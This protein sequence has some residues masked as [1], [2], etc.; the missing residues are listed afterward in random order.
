MMPTVARS[1]WQTLLKSLF[2]KRRPAKG[3]SGPQ[4][5][6]VLERLETRLAPAN[7]TWTGGAGTLVWTDAN[8]WSTHAVPVTADDVTINVTVAGPI[9]VSGT[10]SI[11]SLTDTTAPLVL[12]SGSFTFAASSSVSKTFSVSSGTLTANGGLTVNSATFNF[13]GGSIGGTVTL[14]SSGLVIGTGSTGA[15]N[16]VLEGSDTL[17]GNV[18]AGQSLWV[19]GNGTTN[20]SATL[21]I[22]GNVTNHGTI[23]LESIN[24]TYGD[25]L[26]TG[27]NTFTNAADGTIQVTNNSGGARAITG[28]LV[29]Q[30]QISV[31]GASYLTVQGTYY[32]AGGSISGPGYLLNTALYVTT[33][34]ASPTTILLEGGGDTLATDNLPNTTLWVQG[35]GYLNQNATLNVAAGLVNH[36]T[37][38]L[39]SINNTYG[40]TL[41]T[42]SNTF[43]NAADGTIQVTNNSG[44]A[45]AI[46]GTL[47][48][49][50][51]V[52][53]DT[54]TTLGSSG[55]KAINAGLIGIAGSTVTVVGSSFTNAVGGLVSGDGSFITP[56]VT[57]TNNGIIDLSRPSILGVDAELSF[58]TITYDDAGAM[59]ATT[60]TNAANYT[61]LGSGGDGIFGNGNDVNESSLISQVTYNATTKTATL[62]LSSQLP[63][64]VYWVEVNGSNV[65]DASG[66]ALLAG[67]TD[68]V[69]RVVG[70]ELAQVA[71]NL[72]PDSNSGAPDHPGYT[73]ISTPTFDFQVNQAGTIAVDFDGNGTTDATLPVPVAG[74]YQLT[75]PKLADG[76]YTATATFTAATRLT[77][78]GSTTYT[79]DT[80][81][82]FVTSITPNG[83][84]NNAVSQVTVTFSEPVDLNTFS[85]AAITLTGPSGSVAVKQPQL[86]SGTT[87]SIGFASQ[88]VQGA[89]TLTIASTVADFAGNPLAP[90]FNGSFTIALPDLA[91][92]TT[93]APS[94]AIEGASLPISWTVT[95]LSATNPAVF[96]W[97]DTVYLSAR[98]VLDNKATPLIEVAAPPQSPLAGN[99][100]YTRNETVTLPANVATG[101]YYLLFAANADAG[102]LE[103]DAGNDTNDLVAEP[104]TLTAPDLQVTGVSGP[105][106]GFNSQ[107]V[108]VSWTDVNNGD[109]P[110]AGPW[111]DNVYAATDAK[112]DGLTLLGS[113]TFLGPLAVGAS[114][115]RTQQ[116]PLPQ[117]PGTYWFAVTTNATQSV[118]EGTHFNNDTTVATTPV[119]VAQVPLPDLVVTSITPP[120]NGVISGTSVPISF[121]V[122]NQGTAP[123]SVPVWHDWVVLSQDPT[124]A[125]TYGGQLNGT[126]PGG[127]QTLNN[128][129][130]IVGFTNP[131][132]LGV[133]E[134]YQQ[135]VNVTLP[136]SAQG[137]WY[138]YV[139]PDGT[140]LHH[141]FAMPELS[142]TDKLAVSAGFSVALT[143]LPDLS[144]TSVQAPSQDFSGQP[145]KLSWTV[146]NGGTGATMTDAWADAVYMSPHPVLDSNATELGTFTHHGV[147]AAGE[148]YTD[149][150][151]VN[152]PVGVSGPFYFLVQTDV[153]GQVFEINPIGNKVAATATAETVNLTPP[154]D[155]QVSA[156][157]TPAT[158]VASHALTFSYT[159]TNAGAGGT[160]NFAWDDSFYLSPTATYDAATA[161]PLGQAT[162]GGSLDAGA[163]YTN[164]I[165]ETL[166]NGISGAYYLLADTDSGNAVFELDKTNNWSAS[167]GTIQVSSAPADLVVSAASAPS[168]ALA[169]SAVLVTWT[170]TNEGL[171]DT[172]ISSW[173]DDIYA[174]TSATLTS[175]AVLLGSFTHVGLL[176]PG[177]SYTQ[178]E[179]VTVPISFLGAYNIFVVANASKTVYV[180]G[181]NNTSSPVPSTVSLQLTNS[182][183][184]TQKAAVSDLQPTSVTG[185]ASA[186]TGGSVSVSWVVQNNGPGATNSDYW[187]DDVWMSTN[188]TLGGG[189]TDIYLG[190]VQ[191]TNPLA[192]GA[193]YSASGTFTL[194]N[195]LAAGNYYFIV[196][197]DR[198]VAPPNDVQG[199][200]LVHET[201][202]ANN[203]MPASTI[204]A[205]SVAPAPELTVSNVTVPGP[206]VSGVQLS[207]G[208]T[209]TNTGADTG[210]VPITDSVY[211]SYDQV[212]DPSDRYVGSVTHQGGLAGGASY[213]Q[214]ATLPLPPGV[215]GTFYVVVVTNS[216]NSVY[217]RNPVSNAAYGPQRVEIDL[218]PIADLVAGT[219]LIPANATAGQ[220]ITITYQVSNGGTNAANGTWYD[221]LYL[222]PTPT[223]SVT[224]PL[225]GRVSQTQDLAPAASYTGTLTAPLPGVAPGSYYVIVRS[226]ILNTLPELT[227]DNNLSASQTELA[228]DAPALTLS[229][230]T[231]GTLGEGQSAYYK[232]DVTA[233]QTLQIAFASQSPSASNELYVNYGTMPTRSQ[234]QYRYGQPLQSDQQ[235]T[236]PNTQAGTYY[237]LAYGASV[238]GASESYTITPSLLP[239]SIT[240]VTPSQVGNAGQATLEIEGA[241][242]DNGTT[243]QLV[244]ANGDVVPDRAIYLQDSST[245]FVTFQLTEQ[246]LGAY[247][248]QAVQ[249]DGAAT[250]LTGGVTIVTGTG[251]KLQTSLAIPSFVLANQ[252]DEFNVGYAN[253]GDADEIAPL[254]FVYSSTNTP[255]GLTP[256]E[257]VNGQNVQF[258]AV[259]Q[260]GP[261]GILRPGTSFSVPVYFNNEGRPF[262]FQVYILDANNPD[263]IDW[264][265][266]LGMISPARLGDPHWALTYAQLQK[267]LGATW[268]SFVR[269]LANDATNPTSTSSSGRDPASLLD[270]EVKRAAGVDPTYELSLSICD[271]GIHPFL[272]PDLQ[273]NQIYGGEQM[274]LPVMLTNEGD[275]VTGTGAITFY[276][277]PTLN[278]DPTTAIPIT[279]GNLAGLPIFL[280]ASGC[281][282]FT[283]TITI[284][285]LPPFPSLL[286]G[287]NPSSGAMLYVI[288]QFTSDIPE[289][290]SLFNGGV[291]PNNIATSLQTFEYVGTP[292]RAAASV[293][294]PVGVYL[295]ILQDTLN[296]NGTDPF[297]DQKSPTPVNGP[298]F[299]GAFES[300][301]GYNNPVLYPY[302][303]SQGVPTISHGVNLEEVQNN[304]A[305]AEVKQALADDVRAYYLTQGVFL[306][307]SDDDIID[308]LINESLPFSRNGPHAPT[309]LTVAEAL[310]VFNVAY[311]LH[312]N[313]AMAYVGSNWSLLSSDAQ[314]AITDL[315]YNAN[316]SSFVSL[317][318]DLRA[319]YIDYERAGF[320]LLNSLRTLQVGYDRSLADYKYLLAGLAPE[321]GSYNPNGPT[322]CPCMNAP[323]P[324]P[325]PPPPPVTEPPSIP[326]QPPVDNP[327]AEVPPGDPG[328]QGEG[329]PRTKRDPNDIIGPSGAGDNHFVPANATLGYEVLFENEPT[330]TAPVQEVV[331]T[332]QLDPNLDW[333]TFRLG[334]FG[335]GGM[336]FQVPAN[337]AYYQTL[338]DFTQTKGFYVELTANIDERT[339]IATWTFTTIDPAAGEIPLDPSVGFLPP[340]DANG[341]GEGFVS[342][343]VEA[344]LADTTGTVIN[345]QA[346][347]VFDT[348]PPLNTPKIFNTIDTGTSLTSSV[349]A[350]PDRE[351][352]TQFNVFWSGTDAGNGSA[353]SSFTIYVSDNGGPY[354]TW[355][356][357]TTLTSAP[358]VGQDGH[359]YAFYSVAADNAGNVQSVPTSAQATTTI[360]IAPPVSS[361]AT[362][363]QFSPGTVTVSWSGTDPNGIGI[364]SYSVYVS[365]DGGA[366]TLWLTDTIQTTADYAGVNGHTYGFYSVAT[367]NLGN[368][369]LPPPSAQA[370][371]TVDALPPSS[372]VAAL[373]A[374]S[375]PIFTV[376]WSGT[377]NPGGSGLATYDVYVSDDGAAFTPLLTATTLTST[378][379]TG[380]DGHTYS[381]YSVAADNVGNVQPTPSAAQANT[382]VDGT[383]PN[384]TVVALPTFSPGSFTVNWSGSDGSGSGIATYNIYVSD[385]GG[386]FT[387]L[388]TNTTQTT[389]TYTG[390]D[391]H[392]YGFYAVATD[393]VGNIQPTPTGAQATTT[394]DGTPPNSS[395]A[396][397]PAFS[398]ATFVLGWSGGDGDGSGIATYS[399]YVS[400]NGGP[401][402]LLLGNTT[403][404]STS[405]AGQNGHTYG[406]Y[407]VATDNVGN[408]QPT[409][410][411]AQAS[412]TVSST[413]LTAM[414]S[415]PSAGVLY[416]PLAFTVGASDPNPAD[417][418]GT[419]TYVLNWGDGTKDT[420]TAPATAADT[421]AYTKVGTYTVTLTATDQDKN[422]S[423]PVSQQVSVGAA[424]QLQDG[425]LAVPGT[426][427]AAT[428]TLT[429]TL[430]AGAIAYSMKVSYT[431]GG[432]T[433]TFGP[434][435]VSSIEVYGGP[436]TD[437]VTLGGTSGSDDFTVG[438]A[439]LSELAAQTTPFTVTLSAIA[440]TSLNGAGGSDS[441]TGPNGANTWAI[442]GKNAGTLN[443]SAA[444]TGIENLTGGSIQD[445]FTFDS[446]GSITGDLVGVAPANTVDLSQ[447][448]KPVTVN[449]QTTKATAVGGT[450]SNI[451]SFIGTDTT[452]A[453]VAANATNTWSI[454]GADAGAVDGVSFEGFPNLTGGTTNDTFA[455]LPAGSIDGSI[456]GGAPVNTLD[457]SGYG[458]R[459]TVNLATKTA[460]GV[461]GTWSGIQD[462]VGTGTADA[463][464]G[465]DANSTWSITGPD[466]GTV[467][468]YSFA[469]FP[470]LTGGTGND[471]FKFVSPGSLSGAISGGGGNDTIIGDN[472]DNTFTISGINA[473]SIASI[474]PHG[475]SGIQNLTGGSTNDTFIFMPGGSIAG[476][477]KGG[478]PVNTLDYSAYGSAVVVNLAAKTATGIGGTWSNI[479]R[480]V[481]TDTADT[482]VGAAV[483]STWSIT[484]PDAGTVGAY[485]FAGF[486]N[487]T[488]GTTGDDTFAFPAGGS[489]SGTVTGGG[490]T[491]TLDLSGYGSPV[492]VNLQ[493]WTATGVG[494][495]WTD[496]QSFKGTNTTDSL[497]ATD[498]TTNAWALKGSN[499]GTVNGASF[500]GFAN[501]VG[502]SGN[503][504]FTFANKA[505]V[506][507]VIDG[508]GG[509]NTLD[510]SAYTGGVTVNLGSGTTDLANDSATGV[511]GGTADGIAN[512]AN[513]IVGAGNNYLTAVGLTTS[514]TFT[515][516]GTGNNILV[517]GAGSNTLTASGSGN[518]I[519]IG[520]KGT[521]AING[522]TGYNLLVGGYTA[523]DIVSADLQSI[524]GIWKTVN[525]ATTYSKAIARLTLATYAYALTAASVHGNAGDTINAGTHLLDWYFATA[526]GEITGETAGETVT[527]C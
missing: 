172:A 69:N 37:I 28:T 409:P 194:P 438:N 519:V 134:S 374:F 309:A 203:E 345:A 219:V 141:P 481:G 367:D 8:N 55:A 354:T 312:Q 400:D 80:A 486:P 271:D 161:I 281:Q 424:P 492:T 273:P 474:L 159:V 262:H 184:V 482:L 216:N 347:V 472:N 315:T 448:G 348:E 186:A 197:T 255:M 175:Q 46:T 307:G 385:D 244:D 477:L 38:L 217:E 426:A 397:L 199:V 503:D 364:A 63:S 346:T 240:Q 388:L 341:S 446:G 423:Q 202:E 229:V 167:A 204:T 383:P 363:P 4:A 117:T 70:V 479:Q 329:I 332:E 97:T 454:S 412:T 443:G 515:A 283:T 277:S 274:T 390:Q 200:N 47:V 351:T 168:A 136:L 463:L 476:D 368:Q 527:L 52:N 494:G 98:A 359:T 183:G 335:F 143:P 376:S 408:V 516:T 310:D 189:G 246:A 57:L 402:T 68:L 76:T 509:S 504:T 265:T 96:P 7:V 53:F 124:L 370:S 321:L 221:S 344:N 445:T 85:P 343:T 518:N 193:S 109:A 120:P 278:Y 61:L 382:T 475:F 171:G 324:P 306:T 356:A 84:V 111:V 523:Y 338:I 525:S 420:F 126:G 284:P 100:N 247:T 35:N 280:D 500:A 497:I 429:P 401:F 12:S 170:T 467:G 137:T 154:P 371:T 380:V 517:G 470:N 295:G 458:R 226:N 313:A 507:G 513:V 79:I 318:S 353:I 166:P 218:P 39:E 156:V 425:I 110:A 340:D 118:A 133:G 325:P 135:S 261:A 323:P 270:E 360:D 220:N 333:R 224:D 140:G 45:R 452:D 342:Y 444:F 176:N 83:T 457:Y 487:L 77:A 410:A 437:A 403:N 24:N 94:S 192:A 393:N 27:S 169:G 432:T 260:D 237:V 65:L 162:H 526:L 42:G 269:A 386:P 231:D 50:G 13:N 441:L 132:Y 311:S 207:V 299:T 411:G 447:L 435:A 160:P 33:S 14:N 210:N 173:Q 292:S 165:T 453:L 337:T 149:S 415:G 150:Q 105:A 442:T 59:N 114:V 164:S 234:Y 122:A 320:D 279:Q 112:G 185:P 275:P 389:A 139:V 155:L 250:Q 259:S 151:T 144:V 142:R 326:T 182:Q 196:G 322:D 15:A 128:Q 254:L 251:P 92:S 227:L 396:A 369:Q 331:L 395:V 357:N 288:A 419:F 87:Y 490:G 451:Q 3:V 212:F 36:G 119:S 414:L 433:S 505:T 431:A 10:Q 125:Q 130:V 17:T 421:H 252:E 471:T 75:A 510:Y 67:Q 179:L 11:N 223:W 16:F 289:S 163:G 480:F 29:N 20:S 493:T 276:L 485:S 41:A 108:L 319:P 206:A 181:D 263:P 90:S 314:W 127:D 418:A 455:F 404:T 316:I 72:D 468:A 239:F 450:W 304:P 361:V 460:T 506:S 66:T 233:G 300:P 387:P 473:G 152:L 496:I 48:N 188:T 264:N 436:N 365:Y 222:S 243:F 93:S 520:G 483:N 1:R 209:V 102:Q 512:F 501:L 291:D 428:I 327:P 462:F 32:A 266:V 413:P 488:G 201:N 285:S 242:F 366:F 381:F 245:A 147:L 399:V 498:G 502:G 407:S 51:T 489:L 129:P 88:T 302:L 514:V 49:A 253:T 469:G 89:Y 339:G 257:V 350:L 478:A 64:D 44:G 113:F 205:V 328:A 378:T 336:I 466:A 484:G 91:V 6:L 82:P 198:P 508:R 358:F 461:G 60:V 355:L 297:Q 268:G 101:S 282:M 372:S 430:P 107:D 334:S 115:Q 145:M 18:A 272:Y 21:T 384:S 30:G 56:G 138:V 211:L 236:I 58:V 23:L 456:K 391:G 26:A 248:V 434:F 213:T 214:N 103:S 74:T 392:T 439:T 258:M 5:R 177:E 230:A 238:P 267:Q 427:S 174:D 241:D 86:V 286:P 2:G 157:T 34:P 524:L 330:A 208:W 256:D 78:Q 465:A 121:I 22:A 521:S 294:Q 153:N 146:T 215:A 187:Y 303:D 228:I 104:I 62:V 40:D 317:Q 293:F 377:D 495:S 406:F 235:I 73:K 180:T 379:Y 43:T 232:V 296:P 131:S 54:N 290:N 352:A 349:A 191:H 362:L 375:P 249:F 116:V 499:T 190:T 449:L 19:Q 25:T 195:N 148:S 511:N 298:Q 522:G 305:D 416:Q 71:V 491:N 9:T 178:S 123:T 398:P 405:F 81:T 287:N 394:V 95:N 106:T 31:D 158:A 440:S 422:V 225:L 308:M 459:V 417:Q 373:P 99:A 301:G 464:A